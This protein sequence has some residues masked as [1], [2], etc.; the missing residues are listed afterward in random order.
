MRKIVKAEH[1]LTDPEDIYVYSFEKIFEKPNPK[2]DV[3]VKALSAEETQKILELALKNGF[4]VVRRGEVIK[5]QNVKKPLVLLDDFPTPKLEKVPIKR[6]EVIE[7]LREIHERGY[8]S[9]KNFALALKAFLLG[10]NFAR[11][12]DCKICSDYC[13]VAPSFGGVETWSSKGRILFVKTLQNGEL[14]PSKKVVDILYTCTQC[15]LCFG[16]CFENLEIN[17]VILAMR[18]QIVKKGLAPMAFHET[19]KN[20]METGD[21]GAFP[22][23]RRLSWMREVSLRPLSKKPEILYWVG[24]MV[25]DR[26]PKTA[27]AL[28]KILNHA[29]VNFTMLMEREGCCGYV[30]LSTGFWDE[31][32]KVAEENVL[33]VEKS[34]V[35]ALV[36][37]CAGCY[38]TFTRLYPKI[39][40]ISLPCEI[41][42]SSQLIDKF[43][44][45]GEVKLKNLN[46]TVTYHD[47]CSLGRHSG[48]F[49]EP[50]NVL[51]AIPDLKFTEMPLNR[52]LARCCGGGGGLWSFNH[53]VSMNC[54]GL[55]LMDLQSLNVDVLTTACPLC[56]INFRYT[57]ARKSAPIEVCDIIEIVESALSTN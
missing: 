42:H 39:L 5:G 40:G 35:K 14:P 32:K 47:P 2:P 41:F 9:P 30:L 8:G 21:P 37:P 53:H 15:G 23:E 25:A 12:E 31:A 50:R 49:D 29:K 55:R 33:K 54:A 6:D 56:Q 17:E 7:V 4:T 10:K 36:T 46:V 44:K 18:N 34:G 26:N 11:C 28:L 38:Y 13:T 57:L 43:I 48:V 51:K 20:I 24:C 27:V 3:V 1:I 16:R 45:N 22:V 52:Q 19:A